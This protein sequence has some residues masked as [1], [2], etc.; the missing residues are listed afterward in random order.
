MAAALLDTETWAEQQFGTCVLGDKRRTKRLVTVATQS[1]HRPDASTPR[2]AE[3]WADC[4]AAYRLFDQA[5]V[6]FEAVTAPHRALTRQ[7]ICDGLWL[8]INDT[9]ELNFGYCREIEGIGRVGSETDRGFFLH[10]ALAVRADSNEL[11]GAIAQELYTRPL[12]KIPRISSAK[13]KKLR[14]RETDVWGRV[15]DQV[16]PARPGVRFVHVC[17]RGADNFDIY[18]HL[19]MQE[20]GW[21]IRA[22][23]LKRR[24]LDERQTPVRLDQVLRR[25]QV[26][27]TYELYVKA[28]QG[29]PARTALMEVR[30]A[31]I[32]MPRPK[33]GV[34]PYALRTKIETIPMWV[35]ET[36]EISPVPKQVEQL[37][38]VLMTSEAAETFDQAW[39]VIEH[40]ERRPLVEEYHK[41][42]KTGCSVESRMYRTASRLEPVIGVAA[43][44]SV[45][46]LQLKQIA[47]KNPECPAEKAVP[48]RWLQAVR[49]LLRRP[50]KITTV[51]D[52]IRALAGLGGFLGRKCDGEPG[53]QTIW[54]GL[55]SLL[56]CI[57]G[58]ESIT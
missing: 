45:R 1:A 54:R 51:R 31:Q 40:Y 22:A 29:Q 50:R 2:Q 52:F 11:A 53:W 4:K 42:L 58:A 18:C 43:V 17:D 41:C 34:S 7:A 14:H 16:G 55:D 37:R 9:T 35:V 56:L 30:T 12:E 27:G 3:E 48:K 36:R 38:W 33:T 46:L 20:A 21:V 49:R 6:T 28:N 25:A 57:R 10:S 44:L 19:A 32:L 23:Q 39:Q 5:P 8:I 47:R 26:L 24:V 15:I 13:R